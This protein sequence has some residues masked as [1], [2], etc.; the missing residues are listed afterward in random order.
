MRN[1]IALE[2]SK[3]RKNFR[4]IGLLLGLSMFVVLLAYFFR[5]PTSF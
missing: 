3:H 4:S 5:E 1:L 2:L